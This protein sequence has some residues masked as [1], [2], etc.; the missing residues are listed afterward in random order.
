M[1]SAWCHTRL[2]QVSYKGSAGSPA[3]AGHDRQ[4]TPVPRQ[5]I[6]P[7]VRG[8]WSFDLLRF[9][10]Q[11]TPTELTCAPREALAEPSGHQPLAWSRRSAPALPGL[12][13]SLGIPRTRPKRA[14][15]SRAPGRADVS[16]DT[17]NPP[18]TGAGIAGS[19]EGRRLLGYREPARNG[20]WHRGLQG[21]DAGFCKSLKKPRQA[22]S[23]RRG[24]TR[25]GIVPRLTASCAAAES[26][27]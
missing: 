24:V 17:A 2:L 27:P 1:G 20:R 18:E 10:Y 6:L 15:A 21:Q 19:R 9:S 16:W 25:G 4:R 7:F 23:W 11:Q 3:G 13:P 8:L 26:Y 22:A 12:P 14:L 5:V